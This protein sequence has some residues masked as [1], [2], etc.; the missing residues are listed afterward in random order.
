MTASHEPIAMA[1]AAVAMACRPLEQNRLMVWAGTSMPRSADSA[2]RRATFR[3]CSPS[4]IAQPMTTSSMWPLACGT[5][6]I[7]P[8]STSAASSSGRRFDSEPL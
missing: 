1:P 4:G 6:A 7:S 8:R 3:P 2:I 5:R